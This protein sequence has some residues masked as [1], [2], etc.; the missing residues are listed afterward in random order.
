MGGCK[1]LLG[2]DAKLGMPGGECPVLERCL[3]LEQHQGMG[4]PGAKPRCWS[5]LRRSTS[6][7]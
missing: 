3:C 4:M 1:V 5:P 7:G 2:V 6:G